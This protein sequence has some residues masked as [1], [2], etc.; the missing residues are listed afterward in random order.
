MSAAE[1]R[2]HFVSGGYVASCEYPSC[3]F[4]RLQLEAFPDALVVHSTRSA[5][6]WATSVLETI[7][8]GNGDNPAQPWGIRLLQALVPFKVG[9]PM[10]RMLRAIMA[11]HLR[12]DYSRAGLARTFTFEW[13]A[14]V[15]AQG[16]PEKVLVHEAKD[17]RAPL[18]KH[19]GLPVPDV[20]YPN[21]NDSD[22]TKKMVFA[23]NV[24]G[25]VTAALYGVALAAV[26]RKLLLGA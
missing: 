9:R 7:F 2:Q 5:D 20:P 25:W 12:G 17:G 8:T 1:L 24:V 13:E 14:S 19:L 23:I 22:T 11:P 26:A 10:G 3:L 21:I 6:S 16:P 4:W 15:R 18:C